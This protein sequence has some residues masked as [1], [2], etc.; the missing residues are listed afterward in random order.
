V[1]VSCNGNTRDA[2]LNFCSLLYLNREGYIEEAEFQG[3]MA[4]VEL[5]IR[6]LDVPEVGGVTYDEVVETGE[7]IPVY[8]LFGTSVPP[9]GAHGSE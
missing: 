2:L 8:W 3:E 9:P 7:H 1:K 5:A 6:Q 4:V